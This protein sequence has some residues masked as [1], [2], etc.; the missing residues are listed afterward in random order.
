LLQAGGAD[1]ASIDCLTYVFA[2]DYQP[3]QVAGLRILAQTPASP[4]IPFVTSDKTD[5]G[6]VAVLKRCLLQ[7]SED[8][9]FGAALSGLRIARIEPAPEGE[10]SGIMDWEREAADLGYPILA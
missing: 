3:E 10:Y 1:C 5:A 6:T 9:R 7:L 8:P 4:A 2:Q